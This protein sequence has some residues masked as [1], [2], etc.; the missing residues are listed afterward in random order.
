MASLPET[1]T[2]KVC[3]PKEDMQALTNALQE[4]RLSES[5]VGL[6]YESAT[7]SAIAYDLRNDLL[8]AMSVCAT[9]MSDAYGAKRIRRIMDKEGGKM[10]CV[11]EPIVENAELNRSKV[12]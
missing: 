6:G 1:I 12:Y 4:I 2:I 8:N 5:Q 10:R 9:A 7:T 3:C 11:D